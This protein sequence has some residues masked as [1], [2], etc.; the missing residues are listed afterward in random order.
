[1]QTDDPLSLPQWIQVEVDRIQQQWSPQERQRRARWSDQPA[2]FPVVNEHDLHL[3]PN[4]ET[5]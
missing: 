4:D 5:L 2:E 3:A 1:M